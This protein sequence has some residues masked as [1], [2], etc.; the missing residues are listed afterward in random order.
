[1]K[2]ATS[3]KLLSALA[4]VTVL[5]APAFADQNT[6]A[7][8]SGQGAKA[9]GAASQTLTPFPKKWWADD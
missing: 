6:P 1:M 8:G 3:L 2:Y 9:M 5:A 4:V 7:V